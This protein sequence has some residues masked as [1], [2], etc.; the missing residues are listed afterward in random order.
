MTCVFQAVSCPL[1]QDLYLQE[2]ES[3]LDLLCSPSELRTDIL[4]WICCGY[5]SLNCPL[6]CPNIL[7]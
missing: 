5:V 4:T 3:M 2:D 1:V 6:T 7:I